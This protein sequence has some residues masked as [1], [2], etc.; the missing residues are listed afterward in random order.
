MQ[1]H[2]AWIMFK[3]EESSSIFIRDLSR[4]VSVESPRTLM[5][6]VI[7]YTSDDIWCLRSSLAKDNNLKLCYLTS[8]FNFVFKDEDCAGNW[9][10]RRPYS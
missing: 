9:I 6:K 2:S 3:D 5:T 4:W 1:N 10:I 8:S 7:I